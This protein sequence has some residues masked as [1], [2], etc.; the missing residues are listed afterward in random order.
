MEQVMLFYSSWEHNAM[1]KKLCNQFHF[2]SIPEKSFYHAQCVVSNVMLNCKQAKSSPLMFVRSCIVCVN[3][4]L[5]SYF[6]VCSLI[7]YYFVF[8][9][10]QSPASF[11]QS[12]QELIIALQ[13]SGDPG[14]LCQMREQFELLSQIDASPGV[15]VTAS[16][17]LARVS[18]FK[19]RQPKLVVGSK[20]ELLLF[21]VLLLNKMHIDC[22]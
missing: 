14:N 9:Q 20:T 6:L 15:Y 4:S 17:T 12:I 22:N 21:D 7:H 10:L 8:L 18:I 5:W 11:S 1:Q 3:I 19:A 2:Y 13:R 16:F